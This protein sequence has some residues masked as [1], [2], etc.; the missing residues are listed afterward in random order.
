[1]QVGAYSPIIH[2]ECGARAV[3]KDIVG[4]LCERAHRLKPHRALLFPD[5]DGV[6]DVGSHNSS[7]RLLATAAIRSHFETTRDVKRSCSDD[8]VP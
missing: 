7:S 8:R 1:M 5:S 2:I 4:Q 6:A 3:E